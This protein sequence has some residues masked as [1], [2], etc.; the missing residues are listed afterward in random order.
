MK[1]YAFTAYSPDGKRTRGTVI[2]DTE[3]DASSQISARGLMPGDITL[4][5]DQGRATRTIGGAKRIDP[6]T[7]SIFT[8]QMAVLLG[9]GLTVETA[10]EAVRSAAGTAR[11]EKLAAQARAQLLQGDA[12]AQALARAGGAL[13]PWYAA[14]VD[15]GERSGQ[16]D[17]VFEALAE[18]LETSAQDRSAIAS[19]LLYPAFVT[20]LALIVCVILM[21]TVA[22]EIIGLF[23]ATGRPLPRL[24]ETVMGIVDFLTANWQVLALIL[25]TIV[26]GLILVARTPSL[27]AKRDALLLRVPLI[28][29]FLRMNAAAQYLRTLALV[30]NSRLPLTE[31]LGI[32]AGV[33]DIADDKAKAQEAGEALQRGEDLSSALQRLPFLSPVAR[34][35]VQAGEA[36]AKLGIMTERAATLAESALRTQRKRV[37][38][39][40]E[41][42]AMV[43]VGG[44]VLVI[45]MAILLPIFDMQALV[46]P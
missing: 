19:A 16:L 43:I 23:Q 14:A 18:H 45:V 25:V 15:A 44:V 4:Q 5:A 35:L 32:S 20:A 34:Q 28:G 6:D 17:A 41:P 38:V 9:A 29:R 30:I 11:I 36:S 24:T 26:A 21:T 7:L 37:S 39:I 33:L 12:L 10:L 1:T 42:A 31:A 13:P 27:R 2:A 22:P 40:L 46:S 3:A 8:R